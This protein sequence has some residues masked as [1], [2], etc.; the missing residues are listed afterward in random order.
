[1]K[2]RNY[3]YVTVALAVVA[4]APLLAVNNEM[5]DTI[6]AEMASITHDHT[7]IKDWL[8]G[9]GWYMKY[10]TYVVADFMH[11]ITGI[12]PKVFINVATVLSILGIT[13]EVYRLLVSRYGMQTQAACLGSWAVLLFPVWHTLTSSAMFVNIFCLWLF[14]I[15]MRLWHRN[16]LLAL[17]FLVPSFQLF[18]L[19]AFAVGF[20]ASD[21][22]LTVG[23]DNYKTK[24][25]QGFCLC[26]CLV[27][28]FAALTTVVNVHGEQGTYNSFNLDRLKSFINFGVLAVVT[29]LLT[30]VMKRTIHD[31]EEAQRF[32]RHML[33]FLALAFFA[34]LAYWAVGRP[35]RY[36]GFGSYTGR[37]T[38]L[39]CIPFGVL[40]A[41]IAQYAST[42][43]S[44]RVFGFVAGFF[45]V[46]LVVVLHQGYSHK[47]AAVV[48]RDMLTES[49]AKIEEPPSGYVVIDVKGAKPPRHVHEYAINMCLYKAYGRSAWMANGFW[50]RSMDTRPEAMRAFYDLSPEDRKRL[51]CT[52]VTGDAYTKYTFTL[53][54]YHQ[55][56][57]VW[58]WLY[59]LFSD[60]SAFNP[61]LEKVDLSK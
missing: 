10:Y 6:L 48:F 60:Y 53:T 8:V 35:L 27:I 59:H 46:A 18:S 16:K 45:I 23:K 7:L 15:A 44:K 34:G 51:L 22:I 57:R 1:M 40:V 26:L 50:N 52:Q 38:Y 43:L 5:W 2:D 20:I 58:Y 30:F 21:F 55:E 9:L 31:E 29:L 49:F 36:F 13:R 25:W 56:G 37:H 11:A 39:T 12:P 17:V 42:R 19:F 4:L 41:V 32:V 3:F 54:D 14:M 28:A 24:I 33:S 61:R 47:V